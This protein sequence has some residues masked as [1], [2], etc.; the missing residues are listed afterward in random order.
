VAKGSVPSKGS[1]GGSISISADGAKP[2]TGIVW[3]TITNGVSADHGNVGGTIYAFNAETLD[4]LWSSQQNVKRDRLGT[5]MKFVVPV[6]ANGRV[7]IPNYDNA[8]NV[9]GLF[10]R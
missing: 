10:N 9:Y 6:I 4:L 5:L 3:G 8:V 7:Y 1:P 2:G